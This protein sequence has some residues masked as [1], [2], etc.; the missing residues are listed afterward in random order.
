[1]QYRDYCDVTFGIIP[2]LCTDVILGQDFLK[3][4]KQIIIQI[5]DPQ[6]SLV[7]LNNA[8]QCTVSDSSVEHRPLFQK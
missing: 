6:E 4:H 1:M 8:T 7:V 2:G 5:N 3:R